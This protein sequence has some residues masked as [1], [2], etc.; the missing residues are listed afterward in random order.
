M[1]GRGAS[2]RSPASE[3]ESCLCINFRSAS[4][5]SHVS[6][7][8]VQL[9]ALSSK[10]T[11]E[12]DHATKDMVAAVVLQEVHLCRGVWELVRDGCSELLSP[13]SHMT[14]ELA[15]VAR[16]LASKKVTTF[17][18]FYLKRCALPGC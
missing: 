17:K 1:H 11:D 13:N 8:L 18:L 6:L 16:A 14:P 3:P 12:S 2:S 10:V 15:S 4:I 9:S 5:S 7:P